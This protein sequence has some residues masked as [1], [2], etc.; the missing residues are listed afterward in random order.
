MRKGGRSK[1]WT[2]PVAGFLSSELSETESL[3]KE[4]KDRGREKFTNGQVNLASADDIMK[5][6][7]AATPR[8]ALPLGFGATHRVGKARPCPP[9]PPHRAAFPPLHWKHAPRMAVSP[10]TSS[11]FLCSELLQGWA[12]SSTS[13][14]PAPSTT[15][16]TQCALNKYLFLWQYVF[17][18]T[19]KD[20]KYTTFR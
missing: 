2:R 19:V 12:T 11:I 4:G 9:S 15:L 5:V 20:M 16:G 6:C 14:S 8:E 10:L 1:L 17:K 7:T 13:F 3:R 18:V